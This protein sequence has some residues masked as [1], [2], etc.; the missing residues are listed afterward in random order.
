[1]IACCAR[2]ASSKGNG[3][4][5]VRAR[6]S[7]FGGLGP[8]LKEPAQQSSNLDAESDIKTPDQDKA[9]DGK[10]DDAST[11][12]DQQE[13]YEDGSMF[14][15]QL[16]VGKR[17][18][19]GVWRSAFERYEGQWQNDHRDGEGRQTWEDGRLYEGQFKDGKFD[20]KG[21]MEWYT[22]QG[23]MV[24]EGDYVNDLKQGTGKYMWPDGR[25]YDGE[26]AQGKRWGKALYVNSRG[27]KR[28]GIW[29]DDKLERWCSADE[30]AENGPA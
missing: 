26:W 29:S 23:V 28:V 10:Q 21:R 13:T 3:C 11:P 14:M 2:D 19:H 22:P 4:E 15:G 24:F 27:E 7:D 6:P 8:D 1:M 9:N 12:A 16:V 30:V 5:I 18:G 17:H 25:L 20:G